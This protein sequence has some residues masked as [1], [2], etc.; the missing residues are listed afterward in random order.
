MCI[1]LGF[2]ILVN[3]ISHIICF[4]A[5]IPM[6]KTHEMQRCLVFSV[7][8]FVRSLLSA[9]FTRCG[10]EYNFSL[11]LSLCLSLSSPL[12]HRSR[13]TP[14]RF[15]SVK[16]SISRLLCR[17]SFRSSLEKFHFNH[18]AKKYTASSVAFCLFP[19]LSNI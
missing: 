18:T 15:G 17:R 12:S 1:I 19:K 3:L 11:S 10:G 2:C 14:L 5:L 6:L 4:S 9:E 13:Y 8:R 7:F 16:K